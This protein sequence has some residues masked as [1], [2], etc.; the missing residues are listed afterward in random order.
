MNLQSVGLRIASVIFGLVSLGHL[1]RVF[2]HLNVTIGGFYVHRWMSAV[3]VVIT[4]LLCV[5]LWQLA[6]GPKP[7]AKP[8]APGQP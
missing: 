5:W 7:P 4:A 6:A 2:L 3:A 8:A 1:L